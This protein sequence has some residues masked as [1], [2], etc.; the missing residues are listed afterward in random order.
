RTVTTAAKAFGCS[1]EMDAARRPTDANAARIRRA[2]YARFANGRRALQQPVLPT[3]CPVSYQARQWS[4]LA[5]HCWLYPAAM[6]CPYQSSRICPA[7]VVAAERTTNAYL[8]GRARDPGLAVPGSI[9]TEVRSVFI[10]RMT[11]SRSA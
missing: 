3:S 1:K 7:V 9:L 10:P 5:P 11:D 8:P 4:A 6:S 2:R